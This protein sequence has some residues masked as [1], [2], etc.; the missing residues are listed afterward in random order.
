MRQER[1]S[2]IRGDLKISGYNKGDG[3]PIE[4]AVKHI[5]SNRLVVAERGRFRSN[6]HSA[7]IYRAPFTLKA[8]LQVLGGSNKYKQKSLLSW[9]LHSSRQKK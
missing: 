7:N 3:G 2:S 4:W 5:R 6:V 1:E 9:S 8:L